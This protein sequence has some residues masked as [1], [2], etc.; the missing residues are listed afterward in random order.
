MSYIFALADSTAPRITA[1]QQQINTTSLTW[2]LIFIILVLVVWWLL[3][4]ATKTSPANL[5]IQQEEHLE[6]LSAPENQKQNVVVEADH[7]VDE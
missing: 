7:P 6:H 2:L 1:V 3:V 4:R 5:E